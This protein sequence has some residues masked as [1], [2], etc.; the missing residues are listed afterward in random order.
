[1]NAICILSAVPLEPQSDFTTFIR[2]PNAF[3]TKGALIIK[4]GEPSNRRR[5]SKMRVLAQTTTFLPHLWHANAI[6]ED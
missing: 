1:M 3:K 2:I 4:Q 5:D 6:N